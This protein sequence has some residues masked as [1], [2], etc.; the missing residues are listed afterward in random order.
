MTD[1]LTRL[2]ERSLMRSAVARPATAPMF[3]PSR[4]AAESTATRE[5]REQDSMNSLLEI[6]EASAR[7]LYARPGLLSASPLD[8]LSDSPPRSAL[9]SLSDSMPDSMPRSGPKARGTG[10]RSS[11]LE[12]AT[13]QSNGKSL[14]LESSS[15]GRRASSFDDSKRESGSTLH[16]GELTG[17]SR[18]A[19]R[20]LALRASPLPDERG[21]ASSRKPASPGAV[22][23]RE[24]L[25]SEKSARTSEP[26]A[27]R[28]S[29]PSAPIIKVSIGRIEVR[30]LGPQTPPAPRAKPNRP[31]PALTLNEYLKQRDEGKR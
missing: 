8:S 5:E 17:E 14:P 24:I 15:F 13:E 16:A 30:A 12:E 27:A 20:D 10:S 29:P 26:E 11:S 4:T 22:R 18:S 23:P 1:F 3:A 2:A 7:D 6:R 25:M 19:A 21:E 9:D 31:G 28:E